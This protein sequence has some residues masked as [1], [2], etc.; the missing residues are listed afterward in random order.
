[1]SGLFDRKW[2]NLFPKIFILKLA[3]T[4]HVYITHIGYNGYM[5]HSQFFCQKCGELHRLYRISLITDEN[6]CSRLICYEILCIIARR[7]ISSREVVW[8]YPVP[9]VLSDETTLWRIKSPSTIPRGLARYVGLPQIWYRHIDQSLSALRPLV[10][11]PSLA[12]ASRNSDSL[13]ILIEYYG[14]DPDWISKCIK[15][16]RSTEWWKIRNGLRRF[17]FQRHFFTVIIMNAS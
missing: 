15:A 7:F 13:K 17:F 6:A 4:R 16:V 9:V 3:Y 10:E 2:S 11:T 12:A 8:R 14:M 1:M 5:F